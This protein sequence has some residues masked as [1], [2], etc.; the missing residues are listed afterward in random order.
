[1][2]R[3]TKESN[4]LNLNLNQDEARRDK[5]ISKFQYRLTY[6]EIERR[7]ILDGYFNIA[8]KTNPAS[9]KMELKLIPNK[10]P[11]GFN[12]I[13]DGDAGRWGR[14]SVSGTFNKKNGRIF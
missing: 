7:M 11:D 4:S 5:K 1:M 3:K 6:I 12:I 13:G 2:G 10:N 14:Y 8:G 9:D